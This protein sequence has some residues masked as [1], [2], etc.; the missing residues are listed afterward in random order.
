MI[1]SLILIT[2]PS[3]YIEKVKDIFRNYDS[4]DMFYISYI[5]TQYDIV[6]TYN[7]EI[8]FLDS[9]HEH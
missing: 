5:R 3:S 9:D 2:T 6:P 1:Y 8:L 4:V 7:L